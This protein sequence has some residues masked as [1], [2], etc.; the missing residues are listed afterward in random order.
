MTVISVHGLT[1]LL[2]AVNV[3]LVMAFRKQLS[4]ERR[5]TSFLAALGVV[6]IVTAYGWVVTP[7]YPEK[8]TEGVALLQGSVPL[9]VKWSRDSR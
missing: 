1:L 7:P 3:L 2:I 9:E 5:L 8:G 6:A 4:A